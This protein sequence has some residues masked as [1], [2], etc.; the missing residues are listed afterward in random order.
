MDY[1]SIDN[2]KVYYRKGT[3]DESV[4]KETFFDQIFQIGF[5][6]YIPKPDHIVIDIGA[7]IGTYSLLLSQIL[8][9]GMVHAFEPCEETYVH[10]EKNITGNNIKNIKA[11]KIALTDS[12]G[13]TKLYYDTENGNW[14]HSIV[15][16]LSSFG[17]IVKTDT[18][19]SFFE[20]N[21][22]ENCDYIKFNCEG[23][24]FKILLSTPVEVL[25]KVQ[26]MLVLYHLDLTSEYTIKQLIDH[27]KKAGFYTEI[28]QKRDD[29]KRG[30]LIV[31]RASA[32]KKIG[33]TLKSLSRSVSKSLFLTRVKNKLKRLF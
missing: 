16:E 18:L 8:T 21:K 11:H 30:W 2:L 10:L 22:I 23:A 13:E 12:I 26:N 33:L 3:S 25:K 6:E 19:S 32:F 29:G 20:T 31:I 24:E 5:P 17:E 27:L 1:K 7:H 15:K 28:R 9:A 14:G 4:I